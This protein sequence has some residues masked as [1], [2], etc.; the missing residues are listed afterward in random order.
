MANPV[1]PTNPTPTVPVPLGV[2]WS[3]RLA[4]EVSVRQSLAINKLLKG[5]H[6]A[7]SRT[8]SALAGAGT[9]SVVIKDELVNPLSQ[10]S[11]HPTTA[12]AAAQWMNVYIVCGIGQFT[13]FHAGGGGT[14]DM[15]YAYSVHG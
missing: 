2:T 4:Q 10:I 14:G 3:P 8:F 12:N 9:T 5:K 7:G 11:Y 6:N 1:G 15:T 13:V